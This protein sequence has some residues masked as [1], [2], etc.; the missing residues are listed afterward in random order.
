MEGDPIAYVKASEGESLDS[1]LRRFRKK[2]E[3]EAI[4]KEFKE[5]QYFTKPSQKRHDHDREIAH[6]QKRKVDDT[7]KFSFSRSNTRTR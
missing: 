4:I 6:K 1:L 3:N 7:E 5:R 2:V